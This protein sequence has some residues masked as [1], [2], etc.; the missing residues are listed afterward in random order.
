MA[1]ASK[2]REAIKTKREARK[3]ANKPVIRSIEV[4][5]AAERGL[6]F[7]MHGISGISPS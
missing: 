4:S 7:L 1:M 2:D 3:D 6:A 5:A